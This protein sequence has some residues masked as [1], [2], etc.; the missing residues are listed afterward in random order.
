MKVTC[1]KCQLRGS[2]EPGALG[3]E[4]R[5]LCV[6]C[7]TSYEVSPVWEEE[8]AGQPVSD[9]PRYFDSNSDAPSETAIVEAYPLTDE[10]LELPAPVLAQEPSLGTE[11]MLEELVEAEPCQREDCLQLSALAPAQGHGTG[12]ESEIPAAAAEKILEEEESSSTEPVF[13]SS[14]EDAPLSLEDE[15]SPLADTS[16]EAAIEAAPAFE[17][18]PVFE[19]VA[20]PLATF[21]APAAEAAEAAPSYFEA[22]VITDSGEPVYESPASSQIAQHDLLLEVSH[23]P[24]GTAAPVMEQ[25]PQPVGFVPPVIEGLPEHDKYSVGV[26]LMR[27]SPV[28]LILSGL[29]FISL[30]FVFNWATKPSVQA[31]DLS[32]NHSL[33]NTASDRAARKPVEQAPA[34]QP[35]SK[36]AEATAQNSAPASSA[37]SSSPAP[38]IQPTPMPEVSS[39]A[40]PAAVVKAA[41]APVKAQAETTAGGNFTVQVGSYSDAAQ[42]EGRAASLRSAGFESRIVKVEIPQRGTW[43]R[44]QSGRFGTRE[45]ATRYGQQL[46]ER[47]AASDSIVTEVGK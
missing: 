33:V 1:P 29:L 5:V 25:T 7:A 47:K 43:Y 46:R 44:V 36:S 38:S 13:F 32:F 19:D 6:R 22:Q 3:H 8:S 21:E 31:S 39:Q 40:K 9:G 37:P 10:P 18:A 23:A 16:V 14:E 11:S 15:A 34:A 26:R 24:D 35:V 17:A 45:E 12:Q 41:E 2:V 30:I 42:A 28:W 4:R 20:E 27:V